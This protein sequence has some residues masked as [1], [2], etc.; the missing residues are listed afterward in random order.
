METSRIFTGSKLTC[1]QEKLDHT[2]LTPNQLKSRFPGWQDLPENARLWAV[3]QS[4]GGFLHPEKCVST[5]VNLARTKYGAHVRENEKVLSLKMYDRNRLV[6][7]KTCQGEYLTSKLVLIPGPWLG[8]FINSSATLSQ[9]NILAQ[10]AKILKPQRNVVTWYKSQRPELYG[11]GNFPVFVLNYNE[12]FFYG[13]PADAEFGFKIGKYHHRGENLSHEMLNQNE[14]A[15]RCK[16]DAQDESVVGS[17]VKSLMP[18]AYG[19]VTKQTACVFTNTP[20]E[21]FIIDSQPDPSYP[22][23]AIVSA[24]SG[25]GFKFASVIGD[26][27][28]QLITKKNNIK[29]EYADIEWLRAKRFLNA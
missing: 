22:C 10:I 12:E 5:H 11:V 9:I 3:Y 8:G 16:F 25:H 14:A 4:D 24:C 18:K 19:R 21:H 2:I 1:E 27:M 17:A 13:F 15:W 20:D 29:Y 26:I 23:L 7:V 6:L 28:A